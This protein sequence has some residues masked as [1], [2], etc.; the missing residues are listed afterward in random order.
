[1]STTDTEYYIFWY[2]FHICEAYKILHICVS[3]KAYK[4]LH[5]CEKVPSCILVESFFKLFIISVDLRH[6]LCCTLYAQAILDATMKPILLTSECSITTCSS[7]IIIQ[8]KLDH[9][10]CFLNMLIQNILIIWNSSKSAEF[11]NWNMLNIFH[12]CSN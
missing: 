12:C 7:Q 4:I 2:I 6:W 9:H 8:R 1:M 3:C 11:W 10:S 5:I